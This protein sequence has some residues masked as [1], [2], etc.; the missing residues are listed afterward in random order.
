MSRYS[1][2]IDYGTSSCRSVLVDLENGDEVAEA[3]Y[4][5]QSGEAGIIVSA[6]DANVARQDPRD[7]VEGLRLTVSGALSAA[8]TAIEGFLPSEVVSVGFAT[9]GSTP[10]PVD[11]SGEPLA[12]NPEF[13]D[14]PAA[15]AWLWKD[16]TAHAEARAITEAARLLRPEMID[17][18]G[19]T[20]SAE[21]FWAKIW[22]CLATDPEV[23]AAAASWVELC[24]FVAGVITGTS[25][26]DV[27]KRSVTAA[28]HKALYSDRWGGLPDTE[29]L[30]GLAPELAELRGRLYDRAYP[31][32]DIAGYV[33]PAWAELTGL[34]VGIPVAV[35]HFDAHAA[36]VAGG[37]RTGT[38]VKVMGTSTCDVTVIDETESGVP[39]IIPGMCGMVSDSMVPGKLSIEAGQSAVGDIFNWFADKLAGRSDI[40]A[41]LSEL[42]ILAEAL[43]PGEHGLLALDWF[44]GNRSVLVDQRLSGTI[45]GMTL[46]TEQHHVLKALVE[47]T[48]FGARRIIQSIEDAGAPLDRIVAAGG[49]PSH[50]PWMIQTYADILGREVLT[51]RTTQGSALGAAIVSAV[52]AGEFASIE[53]AQDVLVHFSDLEYRPDPA[54]VEVYDRLYEEFVSV[55]DAFAANGP[56]GQV[57]KTLL[58]VRDST[59]AATA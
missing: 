16:H 39:P 38:F 36:G 10:L 24:D 51:A 9:T 44:N 59:L 34:E 19:G 26:P 54:K 21:W 17:A 2:G 58:D 20:Y 18:C 52:A 30:A 32:T 35:G 46:H 14:R 55:H 49:L 3:V 42:G 8:A 13:T 11:E 48:A 33:T 27:L 50:A 53:A 22:H 15:Y 5:Y 28:G 23:F 4:L 29:F 7:Y 47:A 12:F 45:I 6:T 57:M 1:L 41:A 37:V 40:S 25:R 56:L 31:T 43:Q